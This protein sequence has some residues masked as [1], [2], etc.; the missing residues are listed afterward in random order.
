MAAREGRHV[1]DVAQESADRTVANTAIIA[2]QVDLHL[3]QVYDTPVRQ[4]KDSEEEAVPVDSTSRDVGNNHL[5]P[6]L[7]TLERF[8]AKLK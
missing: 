3:Q 2:P 1:L 8:T 6:S 5:P 7:C 4:I